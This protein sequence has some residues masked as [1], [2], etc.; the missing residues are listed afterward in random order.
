MFGILGLVA[1]PGI[2]NLR[3]LGL[4]RRHPCCPSLHPS[5][6][7][8][9]LTSGACSAR[10]FVL[11]FAWSAGKFLFF[12]ESLH[13]SFLPWSHPWPPNWVLSSFLWATPWPPQCG[14]SA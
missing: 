10:N 11:F 1:G 7:H 9:S 5:H 2:W 8:Q 3:S 6:R 4:R 13:L 14:W 12:F